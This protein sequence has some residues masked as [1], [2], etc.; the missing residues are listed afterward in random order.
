MR[1]EDYNFLL[2][3]WSVDP[4]RWLASLAVAARVVAAQQPS[5]AFEEVISAD[6]HGRKSKESS[7]GE[8]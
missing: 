1:L 5:G 4:M 3:V 8:S 7:T 6:G 2:V